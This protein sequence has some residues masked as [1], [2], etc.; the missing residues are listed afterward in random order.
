MGGDAAGVFE[1]AEHAFDLIALP[2]AARFEWMGC[3]AVGFVGNDRRGAAPFEP[4]SELV[5]IVGLVSQDLA[6]DLEAGQQ[7]NG[8]CAIGA[9]AGRQQK[10]Y[11]PPAILC[12]RVDFGRSASAAFTNGLR[13]I[14]FLPLAERCALMTVLSMLFS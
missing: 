11:Q 3:C 4:V 5:A 7:R 6:G 13:T 1:T 12:N 10:T 14:H 9:A 8:G 2:V